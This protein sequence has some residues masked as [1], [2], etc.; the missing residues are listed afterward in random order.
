MTRGDQNRE[1]FSVSGFIDEIAAAAALDAHTNGI[2]LK[3]T[4]HRGCLYRGQIERSLAAVMQNLLQNAIKF[5]KPRS[6]VTLRVQVHRR[7][8][9]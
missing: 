4:P 2:T 1:L 6:T 5:T 7:I 3:V 8:G 9:C